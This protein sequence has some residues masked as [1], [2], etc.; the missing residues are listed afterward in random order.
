MEPQTAV[1]QR[2]IIGVLILAAR[3]KARRTV[4]QVAQQ[5]S[6][7]PA[8]MRQYERGTRDI[9]LPELEILSLYLETPLSFLVDGGGTA[10][11]EESP[12]PP[13]LDAIRARRV[14]LGAKLKQARLAA[15][16]TKKDCADILGHG[17]ALIGRYERGLSDIP[18]SE[19]Q[20][21][22]QLLNVNHFYFVEQQAS[23][24]ADGLA[25]LERLARLPKD[26]RA[27]VLDSTSLPYLRMAMK[28]GDLPT[29][30]LKELGEIMLVVR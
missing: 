4:A 25:A 16:K 30:R 22:A 26:V 12:N 19:L 15:G 9:S 1:L 27:F 20:V 3:E 7:T 28:F 6:V 11:R 14:Q 10:I 23:P 8:R 29:D 18:L 13:T 21:L 2:K 24:D 17:V 5:L